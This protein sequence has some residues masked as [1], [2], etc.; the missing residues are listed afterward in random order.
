VRVPIKLVSLLTLSSGA[1]ACTAVPGDPSSA[2]EGAE[3]DSGEALDAEPDL[4]EPAFVQEDPAPEPLAIGSVAD[5]HPLRVPDG[6][7]PEVDDEAL[8]AAAM[9]TGF[10]P[11]ELGVVEETDVLLAE[12]NTATNDFHDQFGHAIVTGRFASLLDH[13]IVVAAPYDDLSG[14]NRNSGKIYHFGF[15][16][17]DFEPDEWQSIG[18]HN[19]R[20][21]WAL[22]VGDFNDDVYDDVAVGMPWN[23]AGTV[24]QAGEVAIYRGSASGL[25]L[26]ATLSQQNVAVREYGDRFGA[27][28]VAADFD[29][30]G[31]DDLAVGSPGED[32]GRGAVYVFRGGDL[33]M[34]H[35]DTLTESGLDVRAPRE[36][37]GA[38][39]AA[40]DIRGTN[41]D[42]LLVAAPTETVEGRVSGKVFL[43][44][45]AAAGLVDSEVIAPFLPEHDQ[46]FGRALAVGDFDDNGWDDVAIG[47]PGAR[48]T[49]GEVLVLQNNGTGLNQWGVLDES[50]A[51]HTVQH[52]DV[53]GQ[54][55][56][57]GDIDDDGRDDLIVGA[58]GEKYNSGAGLV[59]A[60]QVPNF[61]WSALGSGWR[62]QAGLG[63]N[64]SGDRFGA[65]IAVLRQTGSDAL[66]VGAPSETLGST[67][68]RSGAAFIYD[69]GEAF[70]A[71]QWISQN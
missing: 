42:D 14:T 48:R 27:A 69:G 6:P 65:A 60:F 49:A 7:A 59:F 26:W 28:L 18:K 23:N 61:L 56:A 45:G 11:D 36:H 22:A 30:D 13:S 50:L 31:H 29:N 2:N 35:F 15:D 1:T 68:T 3:S 52:G 41:H 63:A 5:R 12:G 33:A 9:H 44:T 64:E 58:P 10:A 70:D 39:L 66:V 40:G 47:S 4:L 24:L 17:T 54:A 20:A 34:S 46:M 55:L 21:G 51:G 32:D 57:T 38:T 25:V 8:I 19:G 37:F 53:F 43:Y 71:W 67:G 62:S 16:G